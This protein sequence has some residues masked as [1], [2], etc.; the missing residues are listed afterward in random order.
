MNHAYAWVLVSSMLP[1][2]AG[3]ASQGTGQAYTVLYLNNRM[4]ELN[5]CG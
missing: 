4:G 2:F 3:D 5:P 1:L